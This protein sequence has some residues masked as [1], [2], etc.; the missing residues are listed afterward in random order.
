MRSRSRL[1]LA[2]K[3]SQ[4]PVAA[5]PAASAAPAAAAAA[6][7]AAAA[8]AP[9]TP[10]PSNLIADELTKLASLRDSG[11]LTDAEFAAQKAKLLG[12]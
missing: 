4:A 6:P 10:D 11:V 12:N 2:E 5:Q 9:A 8:P 3:P 1:Q 7:V